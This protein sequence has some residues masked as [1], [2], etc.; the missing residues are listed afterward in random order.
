MIS[1]LLVKILSPIL[2]GINTPNFLSQLKKMG[3]W[4]GW[5]NIP[6][7]AICFEK[8]T[9]LHH[10]YSLSCGHIFCDNCLLRIKPR[11]QKLFRCPKC[12]TVVFVSYHIPHIYKCENCKKNIFYLADKDIEIY[13]LE[14]DHYLCKNCIHLMLHVD[15]AF[16]VK[17]KKSKHYLRLYF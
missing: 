1:V 12:R 10:I 17:C 2:L 14:C 4:F 7:C 8:I 13:L 5:Y 9:N 3:N 15:L 6:L 16:C 11:G